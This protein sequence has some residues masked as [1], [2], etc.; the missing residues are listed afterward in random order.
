MYRLEMDPSGSSG[1]APPNNAFSLHPEWTSVMEA[2]AVV[3]MLQSSLKQDR[4]TASPEVRAVLDVLDTV[5]P[6]LHSRIGVSPV[7]AK[8]SDLAVRRLIA[9]ARL[10]VGNETVAAITVAPDGVMLAASNFMQSNEKVCMEVNST[11]TGEG[12]RRKLRHGV[13]L[14][15][16]SSTKPIFPFG[17]EGATA[18]YTPIPG[19][20]NWR[21]NRSSLEP[22]SAQKQGD[23]MCWL[24]RVTSE[25]I[26]REEWNLPMGMMCGGVIAPLEVLP[27]DLADWA[28]NPRIE[29]SIGDRMLVHRLSMLW[30]W[31]VTLA[32]LTAPAGSHVATATATA[33]AQNHSSWSELLQITRRNVFVTMLPRVF[34]TWRKESKL[35]GD[36]SDPGKWPNDLYLYQSI[37]NWL[38]AR[39]DETFT[40]SP[41][42]RARSSYEVYRERLTVWLA[43][44]VSSLPIRLEGVE[45]VLWTKICPLV[46][47]WMG[48]AGDTRIR[49]RFL[50]AF[51]VEQWVV[52]QSTARW[53]SFLAKPRVRDPPARLLDR[54]L[55]IVEKA[56]HAP[57]STL[58]ARYIDAS[59]HEIVGSDL[60]GGMHAEMR[61]LCHYRKTYDRCPPFISISIP[62][63]PHCYCVLKA[64]GIPLLNG[65][66][67]QMYPWP[68]DQTFLDDQELMGWLLGP[69][70]IRMMQEGMAAAS[71]HRFRFVANTQGAN[72]TASFTL[73]QLFVFCISYLSL[74]NSSARS[75]PLQFGD[76]EVEHSDTEHVEGHFGL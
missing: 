72:L 38:L 48:S 9:L 71:P 17:R 60:R 67:G 30:T 47:K 40:E 12:T 43:E 68:M 24:V 23:D 31:L 70:I 59:A 69:D 46:L 51:T 64:S 37:T 41:V 36:V 50:D 13:K 8:H 76:T 7:R 10:L 52:A 57:K 66:H 2:R 63:C 4:T 28:A 5:L 35:P 49:D 14:T 61:V 55:G 65:G 1:P 32:R 29:K 21:L 54:I 20:T 34:Q 11:F 56:A 16:P 33:L 22:A 15:H 26:R 74:L 3:P 73:G 58:E 18:S 39:F 6:L 53:P 19:T 44:C 25:Q 62:C 42:V 75:P 45:D 27:K